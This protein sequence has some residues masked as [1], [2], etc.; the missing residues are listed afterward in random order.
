MFCK[1]FE[2]SGRQVLVKKGENDHDEATIDCTTET[3]FGEM[4]ISHGFTVGASRD[5]A[6]DEFS[7]EQAKAFLARADQSEDGFK[8]MADED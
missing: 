7:E 1:L 4:T 8:S 3:S 2:I 6:F 5:E